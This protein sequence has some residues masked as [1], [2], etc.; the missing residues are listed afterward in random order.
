VYPILAALVV[1]KDLGINVLDVLQ[2][3][4]TYKVPCGR[5]NILE[6]VDNI[7]IIDDTYNS[8][9]FACE[10]ALLTLQE[11]K[12]GVNPRG[13]EYRKIAILGSTGSIG[14]QALEIIKEQM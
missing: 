6:G 7:T 8:S 3:L 4:E 2:S 5:M 11:I 9:P 10:S 14:R 1:A 12:R 13:G